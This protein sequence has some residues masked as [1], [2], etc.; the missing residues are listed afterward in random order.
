MSAIHDT[1]PQSAEPAQPVVE[2][3]PAQPVVEGEP[4]PKPT[5]EAE[6]EPALTDYDAKGDGV[7]RMQL[8]EWRA[9]LNDCVM[10]AKD[11]TATTVQ[12]LARDVHELKKELRELRAAVDSMHDD[13][14]TPKPTTEAEGEPAPKPT[15]EA[16]GEPAPKPT[17]EAEGEPAP[18]PTTETEPTE[19]EVLAMA[20]ELQALKNKAIDLERVNNDLKRTHEE[21][22]GELKTLAEDNER[23]KKLV[24]A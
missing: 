1:V 3:E 13:V 6:G 10:D 12:K 17:T 21:L 20:K 9:F 4:A 5:T 14:R 22:T 15:T 23:I 24:K 16:E 11:F 2:G 18:K 8:R 7:S 19:K